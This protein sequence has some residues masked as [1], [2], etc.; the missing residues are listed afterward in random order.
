MNKI[1]N[2]FKSD[3]VSFILFNLFMN[4][5]II[6]GHIKNNVNLFDLFIMFLSLYFLNIFY[7]IYF[8][9]FTKRMKG[10]E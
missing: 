7:D 3:I 10:K 2:F 1:K 6:I 5:F 8:N 9:N 4:I